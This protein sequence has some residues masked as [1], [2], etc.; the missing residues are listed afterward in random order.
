MREINFNPEM[1]KKILIDNHSH[2]HNDI[3][4]IHKADSSNFEKNILKDNYILDNGNKYENQSISRNAS[5]LNYNSDIINDI[6]LN[7]KINERFYNLPLI[8]IFK[9]LSKILM[10]IVN[11]VVLFIDSPN[12]T[13]DKLTNIFTQKNRL[14]YV[15]IF[16]VFLSIFL[17]LLLF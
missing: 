11:E 13:F 8:I 7:K 12:K 1:T 6:N 5:K 16:F 2:S 3:D 17:N 10:E 4:D 15:G 9:N 14:I